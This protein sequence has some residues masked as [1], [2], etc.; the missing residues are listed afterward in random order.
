LEKIYFESPYITGVF[1]G[2]KKA[3]AKNKSQRA[4]ETQVGLG[5]PV[6]RN[7]PLVFI[8]LFCCLFLFAAS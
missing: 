1:V 7:R 3:L 4:G 8:L 5:D 6:F 2:V